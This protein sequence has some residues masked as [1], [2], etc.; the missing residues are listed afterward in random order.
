VRA[1]EKLT[2]LIE[3]ESAIR[4]GHCAAKRQLKL[5]GDDQAVRDSRQ[6]T[7]ENNSFVT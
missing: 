2:A 6:L 4:N 5:P 3:L 7:N 1:D